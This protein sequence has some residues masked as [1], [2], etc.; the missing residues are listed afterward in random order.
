MFHQ[1]GQFPRP[2][3][4]ETRFFRWQETLPQEMEGYK[5]ASGKAVESRTLS[6]YEKPQGA[7]RT[8]GHAQVCLASAA[9]VGKMGKG[10]FLTGHGMQYGAGGMSDTVTVYKSCCP[11]VGGQPL[12][13]LPCSSEVKA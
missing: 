7:R 8:S 10:T 12:P 4:S 11:V 3:G 2:G 5:R 6:C 13:S 1:I 9:P